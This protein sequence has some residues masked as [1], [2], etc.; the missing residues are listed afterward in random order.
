M[1]PVSP[2]GSDE[3]VAEC[4]A[5]LVRLGDCCALTAVAERNVMLGGK[6]KAIGL[7]RCVSAQPSLH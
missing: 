1:S 5:D 6:Q 7:P 3:L 4:V 2:P